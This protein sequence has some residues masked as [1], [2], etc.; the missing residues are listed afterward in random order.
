MGKN[1]SDKRNR[2]EMYRA[3][4]KDFALFANDGWQM[5]RLVIVSLLSKE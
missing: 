2:G 3:P 1:L 5:I 4:G